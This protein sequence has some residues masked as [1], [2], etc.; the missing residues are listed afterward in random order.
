MAVT[1]GELLRQGTE[2]LR[3]SGSP[4]ARLD[5]ELL[6]GHV[7]GVERTSVLA[8][9]DAP[10]GDGQVVTW[11]ALLARRAAGEPVA[12]LRG[13]KEFLGIAFAVDSRALIPRPETE[14]LV[15]VAVERLA[16]TLVSAPRPLDAPPLVAWDLGTGS[17]AVVVGIAVTLRRRGFLDAVRLLASDVSP[18]ALKVAIENAVAHGV[19]DRIDFAVGDLVAVE[20]PP[21][22]VHLLA[23]NLPYV[24]TAELPHLTADL[25]HEPVVALDGGPDGLDVIRRLLAQ[26]PDVLEPGG[27][28][29]LEIGADQGRR[30][31]EAVAS[32]LPGWEV[33]VLPDL[34]GRERLAVIDLPA[35]GR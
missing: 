7:L 10:V 5:A 4:S 13:I 35:A 14:L 6:L 31:R 29:L 22:R 33:S 18:D 12:Y 1:V 34:A 27:V 19:A 28:A 9:P 32:T 17:G 25:A 23:A 11:H 3:A 2:R 30:M 20:P 8:H 16:N 24:P 15:E 26:L 21:G